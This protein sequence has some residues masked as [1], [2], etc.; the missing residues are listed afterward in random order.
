[1]ERIVTSGPEAKYRV[2]VRTGNKLGASTTADVFITLYGTK[3]RSA[4]ILLGES[5]NHKCQFVKGQVSYHS[6]IC[7]TAVYLIPLLNCT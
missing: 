7:D 1:M 3:G 6:I 2:Y 5:K 4:E